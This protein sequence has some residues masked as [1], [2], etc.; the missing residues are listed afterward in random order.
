MYLKLAANADPAV[1]T[2]VYC[3]L[4]DLVAGTAYGKKD[5][6]SV[7]LLH[8]TV[9]LTQELTK[10]KRRFGRLQYTIKHADRSPSLGAVVADTATK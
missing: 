1:D 7:K 4:L 9:P 5:Y 3:E 10:L 8:V 6:N 2:D